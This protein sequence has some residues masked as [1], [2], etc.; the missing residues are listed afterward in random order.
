M[1]EMFRHLQADILPNTVSGEK[2]D[3]CSDDMH[4]LVVDDQAVMKTSSM[5]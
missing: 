4:R 3:C 5:D 2:L 1:F